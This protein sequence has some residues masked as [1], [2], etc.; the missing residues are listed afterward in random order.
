MAVDSYRALP[1]PLMKRVSRPNSTGIKYPDSCSYLWSHLMTRQIA[2]LVI[3]LLSAAISR[4]DDWPQWGG[5]KR[6][7]VW[8]EKGIVEKLPPTLTYRWRT[9]ISAG[10]AGPAVV[11]NKVFV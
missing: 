6:D 7:N 5:P 10:Y 3:G 4:G 8:R 2:W 11:G 1:A 9:P